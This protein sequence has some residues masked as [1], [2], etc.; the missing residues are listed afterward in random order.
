MHTYRTDG[1]VTT[2]YCTQLT[3]KT[4]MIAMLMRYESLLL[5]SRGMS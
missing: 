5:N 3:T 4:S 1:I 2:T